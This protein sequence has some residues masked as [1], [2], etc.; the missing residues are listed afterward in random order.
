GM[1]RSRQLVHQ[2]LT[3]ER[4]P[5]DFP[6]PVCQLADDS[7]L[8]AW[9]E[10]ASWLRQNDMIKEHVLRAALEVAIINS[11]LELEH[12]KQRAPQLTREVLRAVASRS[13]RNLRRN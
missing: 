4:G 12:Q 8:W 13:Q 2:Y 6:P 1:G 5:G 10:V 11:V 9:C 3:G 7:P